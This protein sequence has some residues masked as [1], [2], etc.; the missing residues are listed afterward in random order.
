MSF[1]TLFALGIAAFVAL[2]ILAHRLRRRRAEERPFPAAALVPPAPPRARRR[3]RLE[4]RA[5]FGVRAL[6]IAALALLGAS[7]LVRCTRLSLSRSSGASMAVAIV[8]DDSMSMRVKN[9]SQ[10]RDGFRG[11]PEKSSE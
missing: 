2:P 8:I 10:T 11:Y 4:D 6:A 9:G 5:L 3:A 7:P 1:V